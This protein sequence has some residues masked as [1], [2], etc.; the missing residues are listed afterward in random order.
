MEFYDITED[1]KAYPGEYLFHKVR[2]EIVLCGAFI[3]SENK[4]RALASGSMME[5]KI[6]NFQKIKLTK[7][8]HKERKASRCKG[9]AKK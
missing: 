1:I 6:S 9:C 8:E 5:D 2:K 4:I 3:P 7:K